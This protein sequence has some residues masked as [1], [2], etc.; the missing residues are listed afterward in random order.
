MLSR[1]QRLVDAANSAFQNFEHYRLIEAFQEFDEQFSNW[2]LRRSRRRFWESDNEAY[3]TLY[4]V[5]TTVTRV[6]APALPFL[7][8]EIY[9][10]LVRSVD[11]SAPESVHLTEY[12]QVDAALI[13]EALEQSIEAVIRLKNLALH[14]RTQSKVKIRQPLSTLY[15]RPRD[16]ADRTCSGEFRLRRA[17]S[18]RSQYQA[19]DSDRRRDH[20]G[21]GAPE[22]RRQENRT[23][24]RK[25]SEGDR[26]GAG[27]GR[28]WK[29]D[30]VEVDGQTFELAP[31]E[32][33]V[34]YEGP[35]NLKCSQEQGTFMALDTALTPELLQEGVARDFNRLV[36]DQRKALGL[37]ISDRIVVNYT[38]SPR[39]AEA[40]A[41]HQDY[42]RSE[43]LAERLEPST[44]PK[45]R[46]EAVARRRRHLRHHHPRLNGL[47]MG[48]AL[49]PANLRVSSTR[50]SN[51]FDA[52]IAIC[53]PQSL[54]TLTWSGWSRIA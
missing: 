22:T 53:G 27:A 37:D 31:D 2:Y 15:V 36:Q 54:W 17:D 14:L 13:D 7:T 6:M 34:S 10:N 44:D 19:A 9:Q 12:P 28:T 1:L 5:L 38:A 23:A 16:A 40:I 35:D 47:A 46:R 45:R 43:L 25:I 26:A 3:Q 8:E 39:I 11:P 42:L 49:P 52:M 32:I 24:R 21:K 18:G 4:T 41:T 50:D 20:A 48:Q 33:I 51:F 29:Q 30:K